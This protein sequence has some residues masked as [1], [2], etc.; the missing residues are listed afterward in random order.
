VL[1]ETQPGTH[2]TG[3]NVYF[4]AIDGIEEELQDGIDRPSSVSPNE[5]TG[6]GTHVGARG[7]SDE[8]GNQAV[9]VSQMYGRVSQA[10]AEFDGWCES[11]IPLI[12]LLYLDGPLVRLHSRQ[13]SL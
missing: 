12:F 10:F 6:D 4:D 7:S 2:V 5:S 9:S 8:R 3:T 13:L 1:C 11:K